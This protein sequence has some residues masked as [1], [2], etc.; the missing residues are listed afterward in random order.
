MPPEFLGNVKLLHIHAYQH[1]VDHAMLFL[2]YKD[3]QVI[4]QLPQQQTGT[5][6]RKADTGPAINGNRGYVNPGLLPCL[7]NE[8][9]VV[10]E[11]IYPCIQQYFT[12]TLVKG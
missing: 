10:Q 11:A 6:C 8:F 12:P 4:P 1:L 2:T 3:T 7:V 5:E 9:T